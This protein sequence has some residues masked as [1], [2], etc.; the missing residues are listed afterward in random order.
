MRR[1]ELS[2]HR[3]VAIR[4]G[5][6]RVRRQA[7][8]KRCMEKGSFMRVRP[9]TRTLTRRGGVAVL[10]AIAALLV[11]AIPASAAPGDASAYGAKLNLSLLGSQAVSAGSFAEA[12][13][14]GP[15]TN[16]FTGVD[17]PTVLKTGVLNA[18]AER[19]DKT[20][21][22]F[23]R[24]STADVKLDL[25]K[26]VTGGIS[27]TLIEAECEATQKGLSGKSK[28]AGVNLGKL[29]VVNSDPAPNTKVDVNLVG[30]DIAEIIFNEQIK[31][32]DGGLTVNA[33]HLKLLG[34]VLGSIGTGDLVLSSATCGPAGL[35]IPMASGAGL[36]IGL[37]LL[38]AAALPVAVVAV[39]R[40]RALAPVTA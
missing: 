24:A 36:W 17:L 38:A 19:D 3:P 7:S 9:K 28:L 20:G 8:K 12:N 39:R 37:G 14:N 18:S 26:A 16:T 11:G 21:G 35:P 6:A 31:N 1:T 10:A 5:I 32:A 40:H 4:T 22:V 29:G 23:S 2:P 30:V 15:I 27:A 13:A 33:V 34:G 25:L